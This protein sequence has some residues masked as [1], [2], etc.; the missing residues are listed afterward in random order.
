LIAHQSPS[1]ELA[2]NFSRNKLLLS[3]RVKRGAHRCC[4][5]GGAEWLMQERSSSDRPL[6]G[7]GI[8]I[9]ADKKDSEIFVALPGTGSH[10]GAVRTGHAEIKHKQDSWVFENSQ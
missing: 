2:S 3:H 10:L 6:N 9:S 4:K 8:G 5:F 7:R 1:D